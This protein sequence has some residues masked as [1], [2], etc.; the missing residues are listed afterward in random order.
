MTAALRIGIDLGGTKIAGI[1][2]DPHDHVLAEKRV[3]TPRGDYE[4]AIAAIRALVQEFE[5]EHGENAT[6]GVGIP[7]SVSPVR[8]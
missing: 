6:V 5:R 2:L 4:G 3:A 8:S 1:A 7:G